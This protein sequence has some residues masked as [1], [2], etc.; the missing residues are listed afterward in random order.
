MLTSQ[1]FRDKHNVF[2]NRWFYAL[3][4]NRTDEQRIF[5]CQLGLHERYAKYSHYF[6][7]QPRCKR[8]MRSFWILRSVELVVSYRRFRTT[9]RSH[10]QDSNIRNTTAGLSRSVRCGRNVFDLLLSALKTATEVTLPTNI[11]QLR[12]IS[13]NLWRRI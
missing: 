4:N 6:W 13:H 8:D 3:T 1:N 12:W 5:H 11:M 7:P 9:Y 10:L 2:R